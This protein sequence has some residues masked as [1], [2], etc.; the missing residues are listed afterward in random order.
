MPAQTPAPPAPSDPFT[1]PPETIELTGSVLSRIRESDSEQI[2]AAVLASLEHLRP[3]MPWATAAGA[4]PV[5]QRAWAREA[6]GQWAPGVAYLY[7]LRRAPDGPVLGTFGLHRRV[8]PGAL[9]IGYWL[10][11]DATGQGYA[12][13]AAAALTAAALALPDISRVE[14]HTDEGNKASAAIPQRLGY[15]L[16]RVDARTA[17]AP[18]ETGRLQ[19]WVTGA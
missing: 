7:T 17:E 1:A 9:E 18:A 2:G 15:R 12:T 8:G 14:I 3:W 4:A 13:R 11:A 19:I 6:E 16:D 5:P 10:H